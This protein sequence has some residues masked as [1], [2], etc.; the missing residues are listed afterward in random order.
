MTGGYV[1]RFLEPGS[2]ASVE[3]RSPL[4]KQ[5]GCQKRAWWEGVHTL[6][7]TV[8]RPSRQSVGDAAENPTI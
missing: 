3:N 5:K 8:P 6:I 1:N 2:W 7:Y 4:T